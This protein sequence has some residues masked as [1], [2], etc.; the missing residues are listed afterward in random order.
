MGADSV[1]A[2]S[3]EIPAI[4][5]RGDPDA[6]DVVVECVGRPGM[7]AQSIA[8]ANRLGVIVSLGN[9]FIDD[10]FAP[11]SAARKEVRLVFPQLYTRQEFERAVDVLDCGAVEAQAMVTRT[12]GYSELP[13]MFDQLR[14]SP[15]D[16][17]VLIDPS[18]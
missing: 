6:P 11:A 5:R 1:R 4:S 3:A 7:L 9:C 17:K 2:P 13:G 14:N 16:C 18:R 8:L 12:V 15:E 10:A